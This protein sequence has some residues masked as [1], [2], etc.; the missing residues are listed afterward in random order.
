MPFSLS[1]L[2]HCLLLLADPWPYDSSA[3]GIEWP[4]CDC[5]NDDFAKF[6]A[7]LDSRRADT[8][9]RA[10]NCKS[11]MDAALRHVTRAEGVHL[12]A[13]RQQA[14][15]QQQRQREA[16]A[17]AKIKPKTPLQRQVDGIVSRLTRRLAFLDDRQRAPLTARHHA[18]AAQ[19]H[20]AISDARSAHHEA[21][22][23]MLE[24]LRS[25]VDTRRAA[26]AARHA[27][28]AE[29]LRVRGETDEDDTL[30][31]L[32]RLLPRDTP[33]REM[34]ERAILTRLRTRHDAE[35]NQLETEHANERAALAEAVRLEN[36]ALTVGADLRWRNS[37]R[38]LLDQRRA[39]AHAI[40]AD[41][42]WAEAVARAR[43]GLVVRCG[44][45][46]VAAESENG[47]CAIPDRDAAANSGT[48]GHISID[49]LLD[50]LIGPVTPPARAARLASRARN[51]GGGGTSSSR[52]RAGSADSE[53]TAAS[54]ATGRSGGGGGGGSGMTTSAAGAPTSASGTTLEMAAGR[55]G[56][57]HP[58]A[59]ALANGDNKSS[60]SRT[61]SP[62]GLSP[63]ASGHQRSRSARRISVP[64]PPTLAQMVPEDESVAGF[65]P[66]SLPQAF[67]GPTPGSDAYVSSSTSTISSAPPSPLGS[68]SST[69]LSPSTVPHT[70]PI[71]VP[72]FPTRQT[73]FSTINTSPMGASPGGSVAGGGLSPRTVPATA[74]VGADGSYF[75]TAGAR[76]SFGAGMKSTL[77]SPARSGSPGP[78][79]R[80]GLPI[81][82]RP[83][84]DQGRS[85][86]G[87]GADSPLS[88]VP[89]TASA[90]DGDGSSA[91][92]VSP[93]ANDM[94]A[95]LSS[96]GVTGYDRQQPQGP[97][98]FG[99]PFWVGPGLGLGHV[100]G[101]IG[102][103]GSEYYAH[104]GRNEESDAVSGRASP[105]PA[106]VAAL[107]VAAGGGRMG[108]RWRFKS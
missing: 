88:P 106:P 17:T 80:I 43:V 4:A 62:V 34:R 44:R 16:A 54:G 93:G 9:A 25:N 103:H 19:L 41:R 74:L 64:P 12:A 28:A 83:P 73:S 71:P 13:S 29:R 85:P 27:A 63:H 30:A 7:D 14:A 95:V 61:K 81:P 2:P 6:R 100:D 55:S 94:A 105:A 37:T 60:P 22:A 76:A 79:T 45:L 67:N 35:V 31:S 57:S 98:V 50:R 58:G 77:G 38:D 20:A 72:I 91:A 104:G 10:R 33:N 46:A 47:L 68:P 89:P 78:G 5:T 51:S 92:S 15:E 52:V 36:T 11:I 70:L 65:R 42:A 99:N 75:G 97:A 21:R 1:L 107:P 59:S 3:C 49:R 86:S 39:L 84:N 87:S 108:K 48:A 66:Y 90:L 96:S 53:G 24:H 56:S 40:A 69:T 23:R 32:A 18:Q 26:L 102:G 82:F 101:L 8:L